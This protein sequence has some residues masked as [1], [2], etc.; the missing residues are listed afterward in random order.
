MAKNENKKLEEREI[1]IGL[2]KV[3]DGLVDQQAMPDDS[4]ERNEYYQAALDLVQK[5]ETTST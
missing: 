5:N 1:I 3:I 4:W 2:L